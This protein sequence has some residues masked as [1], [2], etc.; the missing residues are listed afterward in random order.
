MP[1]Q[2]Y[3][4][5]I[6]EELEEALGDADPQVDI[7]VE[8]VEAA[9]DGAPNTC[10]L[11]RLCFPSRGTRATIQLPSTLALGFLADEEAAVDEWRHWVHNLLERFG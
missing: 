9:E 11:I 8:L 5:L 7:R 6:H 4:R 2:E 1:L 10:F 3:A